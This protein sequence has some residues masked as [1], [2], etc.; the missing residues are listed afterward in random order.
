MGAQNGW[1]TLSLAYASPAYTNRHVQIKHPLRK[2]IVCL[3]SAQFDVRKLS[4][5]L[6]SEVMV[7]ALDSLGG[8]KVV[9]SLPVKKEKASRLRS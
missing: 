7:G 3:E 5:Y 8:Q 6:D 2:A 9:E 1:R 4:K